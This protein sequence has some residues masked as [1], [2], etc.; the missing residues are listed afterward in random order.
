MG[1]VYKNLKST[2]YD[3]L[4]SFMYVDVHQVIFLKPKECVSSIDA[5]HI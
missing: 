3:I 4:R 2:S 5:M 1:V